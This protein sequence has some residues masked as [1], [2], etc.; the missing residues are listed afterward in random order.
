MKLWA[1][2]SF[3]TD[4]N[5]LKRFGS[6]LIKGFRAC[7]MIVLGQPPALTIGNHH[8]D[9]N[10]IVQDSIDRAKSAFAT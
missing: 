9:I 10:S 8:G 6:E 3:V 5:T 2:I 7:G 1:L 4:T